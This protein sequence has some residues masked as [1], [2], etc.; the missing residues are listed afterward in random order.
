MADLLEMHPQ[1]VGAAGAGHE[2]KPGDRPALAIP[3]PLQHPPMG[4]GGFTSLLHGTHA[5][6]GRTGANS[7]KGAI[8][9][10][11]WALGWPATSAP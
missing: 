3:A 9:K 4:D 10:A 5:I 2:N 8:D 1:L 6:A 7:H 11:A